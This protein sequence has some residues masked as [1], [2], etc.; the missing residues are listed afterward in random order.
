MSASAS[1]SEQLTAARRH[2]DE[3]VTLPTVTGS[4]NL[5]LIDHVEQ[6]LAPLGAS[7]RRTFDATGTRANLLAT[8]GPAVDGGVVLSGHT[9]VVPADAH[10]WRSDPFGVEERDGRL[11]GRGTADMKGFLA[12]ALAVAP[13]FAAAALTRPVHLAFTFDEEVGC[14]GAPL[15][16]E[17]LLTA[18]PPPAA[19]IVGEPTQLRI[20]QAHKGCFEFTT[21][22]TGVAGHGS[23]P[24]EAVSAV[25]AA[26]RFLGALADLADEL[27][28][29]APTTSPFVPP[30]STLNPGVVVGGS[31]RN[32]VADRCVIE[33]ELRTVRPGEADEVLARVRRI[34]QELAVW[35]RSRAP[36]AGLT[37]ET[38]GA[39]EGLAPAP[40]SAAVGLAR[41]L[42]GEPDATAVAPEVASFGT[43]AGLYQAAGIPAV[44]CGPGSI[45]V[46]HRPE[47]HLEVAQLGACLTMLER[48]RGVLSA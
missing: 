29:E 41:R 33:W 31:A 32:V 9:D 48:L 4:S 43:E 13:A 30:H 24:D 1:W 34:E 7:T 37:T 23:A 46:A 8:L 20:V 21:T 27:R 36:T 15:L 28:A 40:G 45:A 42:L 39:V 5:A 19:A 26:G 3:L 6:V 38:V 35:L 17:D 12:C 2:L 47:E 44:V 10:G 14:L 16:I 11:Y 25:E 18:V 22:I